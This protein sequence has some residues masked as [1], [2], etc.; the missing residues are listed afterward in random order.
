MY[1]YVKQFDTNA[2]AFT[3]GMQKLSFSKIRKILIAAR[4]SLHLKI[5]MKWSEST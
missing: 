2:E 4:R 1:R 3:D 5:K